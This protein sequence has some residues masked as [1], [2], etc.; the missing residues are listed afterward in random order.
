M[1][2]RRRTVKFLGQRGLILLQR[3][4]R[5][6]SCNKKGIHLINSVNLVAVTVGRNRRSDP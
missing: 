3:K 5:S 6:I 1:V 2:D 4:F